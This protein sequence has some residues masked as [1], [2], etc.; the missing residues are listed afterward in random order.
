[1]REEIVKYRDEKR[2]KRGGK[3]DEER[4]KDASVVITI[5]GW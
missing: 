2:I 5:C 4:R 1:M 3:R